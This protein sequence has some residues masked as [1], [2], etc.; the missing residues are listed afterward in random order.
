MPGL[1]STIEPCPRK[2]TPDEVAK[3]IGDCNDLRYK[4]SAQ[5]DIGEYGF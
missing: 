1:A 3:E 4:G 5:N 2:G